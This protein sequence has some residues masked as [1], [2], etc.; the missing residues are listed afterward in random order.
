VIGLGKI[1]LSLALVLAKSGHR[2]VGVDS[3]QSVLKKIRE[4]QFETPSS[5]AAKTLLDQFFGKSFSLAEDLHSALSESEV[6]FI[7]IG[8]GIGVD[9]TPELSGLSDLIEEICK[10]P[11]NVEQKLFVLKSTLP[12]GTT[13]KIV[14]IM[15]QKT[16][17]R[18]GKD[19]FVAFCPERVLGDKTISE[20][21]SLPKI[22]GGF[23]KASSNKAASIYVTIGGKIII[24]G[25]PEIAELIKLM[26]NA[27]R[28]TLFAFANDCALLAERFGVNAYELIK[29][30]NDS[31]ARNNIPLPSAGVSGYCLTK[32]PLY[33]EASFKEIALERGFNSVWY[34]ARKSN[35]YMPIHLID[36]LRQKLADVGKSLKGANILICGV[37]YKENTEDIRCSHGLDI[38]ADLRKEGGNVFLWDP[39]V[40][41]IEIGYQ[42]VSDPKEVIE[43]VDALVFT[44]K[45]T[46]FVQLKEHN[47]ILPLARRMRTSIIIDGCGIFQDLIE[48]KDIRYAGVGCKPQ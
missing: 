41:K 21:V 6:V 1:G 32:D 22:I 28:Q 2:V 16:A 29:T 20:M 23:D 10:T 31:Y 27:Y 44:V 13:K 3:N 8:T 4:Y 33:L 18:C 9:G 7:A 17:L 38:A 5:D 37:T 12:V 36:L 46:E 15:E 35:D 43:R 39:H 47:D 19:F 26:D 30:A 42:V 25:R 34:S 40:P 45:H 11:N 14:A 48:Q 24:V